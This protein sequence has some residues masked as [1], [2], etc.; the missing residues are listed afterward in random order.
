MSRHP[1]FP[2]TLPDNLLLLL[3]RRLWA[4]RVRAAT[5]PRL[6]AQGVAKT[7]ATGDLGSE[8]PC[9][10]CRAQARL[11]KEAL[12]HALVMAPASACSACVRLP[13]GSLVTR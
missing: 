11:D 5:R 1:V 4:G 7:R 8:S 12:V 10:R 2:T 6:A 9:P 13:V 3:G